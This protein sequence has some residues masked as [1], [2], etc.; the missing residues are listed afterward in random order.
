MDVEEQPAL[1]AARLRERA[2]HCRRMA[3]DALS[4]EIA[5]ELESIAREYETGADKL[6]L[7]HS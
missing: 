6:E 5:R 3:G 2:A 7:G 4:L 1:N